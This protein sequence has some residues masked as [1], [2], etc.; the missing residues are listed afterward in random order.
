MKNH[1]LDYVAAAAILLT[2]LIFGAFVVSGVFAGVASLGV[3]A[4]AGIIGALLVAGAKSSSS[5]TSGA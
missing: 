2:G 3:A 1:A 4:I 5:A